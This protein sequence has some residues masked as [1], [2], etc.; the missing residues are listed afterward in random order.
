MTRRALIAMLVLIF[1]VPCFGGGDPEFHAVVRTIETQYGV[2]HMRIPFGL[3]TFCLK[4]AQV[5]CTSGLKIAVFD[6]LLRAN[7]ISNEALQE[8]IESAVGNAWRPLV[9]VRSNDGNQ[10]T[11]V[12]AN[13]SAKDVHA[14]IICIDADNATVVQ[15]KVSVAQI[16]KWM[17]KPDEI[18]H[19]VE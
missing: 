6:H 2:H 3:A 14:L 16:R 4:V 1:A 19:E 15:A 10:L 8:S 9:R 7:G 17:D 11:L 18:T 12:Y 13:P 5:P